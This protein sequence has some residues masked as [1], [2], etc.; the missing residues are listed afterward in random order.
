MMQPALRRGQEGATL[1]ISLVML[2]ILTVLGV[3]SVQN[4]GMQ[5]IMSRNSRDSS[6][7]FQGAESA[8]VDSEVYIESLN[9]LAPFESANTEGRYNASASGDVDLS[10]FVWT[11][12]EDDTTNNSRGYSTVG[13]AIAGVA[14]QPKY[15]IEYI[16]TVV[17]DEDLLNIE[18]VAGSGGT[19][20]TNVF[21]VT[22]FGTGGTTAARVMLQ[23]TYGKRF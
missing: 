20:R 7:A 1:F 21:R 13:T 17:T 5:E 14:T 11:D 19:S 6:M 16:K 22:T 4:T 10:A 12:D 9:S 2:L 15:I 18:N 8:V 3:S 23:T